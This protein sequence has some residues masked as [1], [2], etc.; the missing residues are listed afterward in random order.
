MRT[1]AG[2]LVALVVAG[3][4]AVLS[5]A[6]PAWACSCAYSRPE[7]DQQA[8]QIVSGTATEVT[9]S[10]VT[11]LVDTVEKGAPAPGDTVRLKATPGDGASCGFTF[12][13]GI[14]YR[15][16]SNEGATNACWYV[17]PLPALAPPTATTPL[18][19]PPVAAPPSRSW[20]PVA[21]LGATV[22]VALAGVALAL[23]RRRR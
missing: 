5:P 18:A 6:A 23:R 15:V 20:W 4:V 3:L 7:A 17:E 12:R 13:S 16:P 10:V 21:G 9:D 22:L 19:A 8:D 11:L 14:R 2:I 1:R